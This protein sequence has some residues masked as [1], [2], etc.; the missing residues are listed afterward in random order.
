MK[1]SIKRLRSIIQEELRRLDEAKWNVYQTKK[2]QRVGSPIQ[3]EADTTDEAGKLAAQQLGAGIDPYTLD[4][5]KV[6]EEAS[7][8]DTV[9]KFAIKR[10]LEGVKSV[11][12]GLSTDIELTI[13][14]AGNGT[15]MGGFEVW[16]RLDS[17]ANMLVGL[18]RLTPESEAL[19][20]GLK[21]GLQTEFSLRGMSKQYQQTFPT[22]SDYLPE[23]DL[24]E[25][26]EILNSMREKIIDALRDVYKEE[27]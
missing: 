2:M 11:M 14:A 3:I 10:A 6:E 23:K 18:H 16:T 17:A 4:V 1:I 15:G 19:L 22:S 27:D 20:R 21:T 26:K 8:G 9:K 24:E 5:E 13:L 12:K 7:Y 25:L